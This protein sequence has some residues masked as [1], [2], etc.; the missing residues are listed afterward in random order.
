MVLADI[1][2]AYANATRPAVPSG[3]CVPTVD[4]AL[5]LL[6]EHAD[7]CNS[8]AGLY[9]IAAMFAGSRSVA[10]EYDRMANDMRRE[11]R[12]TRE[13]IRAMKR[14]DAELTGAGY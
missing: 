12:N 10:Y 4:S 13:C 7:E 5:A 1:G 9:R 3:D 8:R 6:A 14:V 11:E 2:S